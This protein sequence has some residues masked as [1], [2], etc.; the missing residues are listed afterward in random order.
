MNNKIKQA[1]DNNLSGLRFSQTDY[2]A[3]V[4]RIHG[5]EKVKKKMSLGLVLALILI[6]LSVAALAAVLLSGKD[7]VELLIQPKALESTETNWFTEEEVDGIIAE[8]EKHGVTLD[9]EVLRRIRRSGGYFK[10][11]LAMAFSR[12]AFGGNF[13]TWDVADQLWFEEFWIR[14]GDLLFTLRTVPQEGELSQQE[15]E[16]AAAAYIEAQTGKSYPIHD[17]SLY[18]PERSFTAVKDNPYHVTR[19]WSLDY[20]PLDLDLPEFKFILTPQGDVIKFQGD[21]NTDE[22]D[23]LERARYIRSRHSR[24]AYELYKTDDWPQEVWQAAHLALK[25]ILRAEDIPK[26]DRDDS[27]YYLIRQS[28]APFN[29]RAISREMAIEIAAEAVSAKF[30]IEKDKLMIAPDDYISKRAFIYAI[31]LNGDSR[32]VWKISFSS[33]YLAE[34]D[35]I[36]GDLITVDQYSPGNTYNRRYVLDELLPKEERAFATKIPVLPTPSPQEWAEMENIPYFK[37]N[38]S[39]GNDTY[40]EAILGLNYTAATATR[41]WG[42]VTRDYGRDVRFWPILM[43]A[44]NDLYNHEYRSGLGYAGIP[45]DGDLSQEDAISLAFQAIGEKNAGYL[46]KEILDALKP[47]VSFRYD[48]V[49]PGSRLWNISLMDISTADATEIASATIDAASGEVESLFIRGQQ[50]IHISLGSDG[51][52][53]IWQHPS[54]PDYYWEFM[55]AHYPSIESARDYV[56]NMKGEPRDWPPEA[57]AVYAL[58]FTEHDF[59]KQKSFII[60]GIPGPEDITQEAALKKAWE[61]FRKEATPLYGEESINK[62]KPFISFIFSD[63]YPGGTIWQVEFTDED[64]G[65]LGLSLIRLD[66]KT[67]EPIDIDTSLSHG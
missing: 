43:Q 18:M 63:L 66:S 27:L 62:A 30:H 28:Y 19:S 2:K 21:V 22:L 52:P 34:V 64:Q 13:Y 35:A 33:D 14:I 6:M 12:E 5:G 17:R 54:L 15:I 65:G 4:E 37:R 50:S 20:T 60:P 51:R 47:A 61:V 3:I 16:S 58:W 9:D 26:E 41:I 46:D 48:S 67:G 39:I 8:A 44:F 7:V 10:E 23:P 55:E 45:L 29:D 57:A 24:L 32:P 59:N 31:G 49:E 40:W 36:T 25:D 1:L 56:S 42:E 38:E 53:L 11:E